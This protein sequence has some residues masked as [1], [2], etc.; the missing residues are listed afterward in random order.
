MIRAMNKTDPEIK[1]VMDIWLES[2]IEAHGFILEEY[3]QK[4]YDTVKD[5]YLPQSDS[6]VLVEEDKILGFISIINK[7]FIGALFVDRNHQ[8]KG[9]GRKLIEFVKEHYNDLTLAVYK[10]NEQAVRFYKN[11]GFEILNEQL[12]EETDE[13]E[14]IMHF[15]LVRVAKYLMKNQ[16]G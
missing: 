15:H 3:W 9:I 8:G 11:I 13:P 14:F 12:N 7:E 1:V 16:I 5:I 4:N 2:T 6:Y 10:E